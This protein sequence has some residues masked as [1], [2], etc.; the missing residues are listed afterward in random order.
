MM[1]FIAVAAAILMLAALVT[2][3]IILGVMIHKWW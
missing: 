2:N 1:D 3:A